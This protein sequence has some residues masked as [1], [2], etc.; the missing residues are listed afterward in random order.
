MKKSKTIGL[1]LKGMTYANCSKAIELRVGRLKGVYAWHIDFAGEKGTFTFDPGKFQP[2][3]SG[4]KID[5]K[6]SELPRAYCDHNLLCL[7]WI[8]L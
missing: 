1:N 7:E 6:V 5:W 8:N 4:R 2:D 3:I